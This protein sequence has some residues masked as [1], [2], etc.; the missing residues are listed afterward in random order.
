[1]YGII[2]G[3]PFGS[4]FGRRIDFLLIGVVLTVRIGFQ[5]IVQ[6]LPRIIYKFPENDGVGRCGVAGMGMERSARI[7]TN[8]IK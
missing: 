3:F 5:I 4:L 7:C 8:W 2:T 6:I 1:M